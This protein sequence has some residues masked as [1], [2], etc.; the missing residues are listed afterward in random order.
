[1]LNIFNTANVTFNSWQSH[2][3]YYE[4]LNIPDTVS[5][6]IEIDTEP[7]VLGLITNFFMNLGSYETKNYNHDVDVLSKLDGQDSI[8]I[9]IVVD[10]DG[11]KEI[12]LN[13]VQFDNNSYILTKESIK[14]LDKFSNFLN[15]N[16]DFKIFIEGHTDNIGSRFDNKKLSVQ[17]ARTV[18]NYLLNQNVSKDQLVSYYGYGEDK[19]I[20]SNSTQEGRALNRRTSFKIYNQDLVLEKDS[21]IIDEPILKEEPV[22]QVVKE[23]PVRQVIKEEPVRQ[24]VKE[25]PVRQVVKEEPVR[26]VVKEE[27]VK[28]VIKEEPVKDVIKEEPVK[29]ESLPSDKEIIEQSSNIAE[30]AKKLILKLLDKEVISMTDVETLLMQYPNKTIKKKQVNEFV[31]KQKTKSK[32]K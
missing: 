12:I 4:Y 9:D 6:L 30:S 31:K 7:S 19:P 10:D 23:E 29:E 8:S 5:V 28:D 24:V 26:Q 1:M 25:E 2:S 3:L 17:R 21:L 18:Y 32:K 16:T 27:P 14:E 13:N 11:I 20:E 22:R 15:D